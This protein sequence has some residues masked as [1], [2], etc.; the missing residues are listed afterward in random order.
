VTLTVSMKGITFGTPNALK[1]LNPT[2]LRINRN[3]LSNAS[4]PVQK[5]DLEEGKFVKVST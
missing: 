5:S 3:Q 2:V 1:N 4:T